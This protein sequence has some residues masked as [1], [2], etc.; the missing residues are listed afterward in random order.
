MLDHD[1]SISRGKVKQCMSDVFLKHWFDVKMYL[2]LIGFVW[3]GWN[4][5]IMAIMWVVSH[6]TEN[7]LLY[8][9]SLCYISNEIGFVLLCL[10]VCKGKMCVCKR[11]GG[12]FEFRTI[13][14][15]KCW[16]HEDILGKRGHFGRP[17]LSEAPSRGSLKVKPCCRVL[18]PRRHLS[19][20]G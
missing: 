20:G 10:T 11:G 8:M 14:V 19:C 12:R 16:A 13:I 6:V 5:R 4:K 2:L 1:E 18:R 3:V 7:I 15:R 17:S 9:L